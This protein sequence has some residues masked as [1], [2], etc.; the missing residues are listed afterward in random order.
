MWAA[1]RARAG[2]RSSLEQKKFK[3][4][5]TKNHNT[6]NQRGHNGKIFIRH[7]CMGAGVDQRHQLQIRRNRPSPCNT[8][9]KLSAGNN[10]C[11]PPNRQGQQ[12]TH[13]A[14]LGGDNWQFFARHKGGR[15]GTYSFVQLLTVSIF[16]ISLSKSKGRDYSR[17][18][19]GTGMPSKE[20]FQ[21]AP[22]GACISAVLG[23]KLPV[24]I[25]TAADA[26]K[27]CC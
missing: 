9:G 19:S 24:S 27:S 6:A 22:D 8:P 10:Q 21:H 7:N 13:P 17:P 26:R 14:P 16:H 2:G 18:E 1:T 25:R 11:R 3:T 5:D 15:P 23:V 12:W 4:Y 20:R